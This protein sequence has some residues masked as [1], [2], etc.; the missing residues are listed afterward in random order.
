MVNPYFSRARLLF[1]LP[2][3]YWFRLFGRPAP[4]PLSYTIS[5]T[6]RCNSRC[7]TCNIYEKDAAELTPGEYE[8]IFKKLGRRPFWVTFSGGEPFLRKDFSDIVKSFYRICRPS[9]INIPTNGILSESIPGE[10]VSMADFCSDARIIVN[11]SLDDIGEKHDAIRGAPG[12]FEKA[13]MTYREL[14]RRQGSNVT[15]GIHTVVSRY[16]QDRF[17]EIYAYMKRL[18]PDSYITEM[19]E[20]REELGTM[21]EA[22]GPDPGTYKKIVDFLYDRMQQ[23]EHGERIPEL[24]KSF[25]M[26][27]YK[28]AEQILRENR[29]V[30]PCYAGWV[31][32]QIDPK[33]DVWMCCVR[34][35]PA[36]NLRDSGYHFGRIWRSPAAREERKRI[37]NRECG[38]PL[39]NAA[40]TNMLFHPATLF[41]V[42]K[43]LWR[44]GRR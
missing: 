15:I 2:R 32:C 6:Y 10:V 33:G 7:L 3:Y 42:G 9:I 1:S 36:G 38:C 8:K 31:S 27:Y 37:K 40:Y 14:K 25:R 26:E 16:N 39:A 21:G 43:H 18:E 19:A 30:I 34:A 20:E 23:E 5:V 13:L 12:A 29:Q 41:R 4:L 44:S 24:V 17:Q 35:I 22:H 28:L 11:L